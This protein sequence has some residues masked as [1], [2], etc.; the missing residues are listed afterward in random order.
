[1]FNDTH[2]NQIFLLIIHSTLLAV[3]TDHEIFF[4]I[5]NTSFQPVYTFLT[6]II[7]FK[8]TLFA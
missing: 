4:M 2:Y 6:G 3:H 8:Q 5:S 7:D 1:M